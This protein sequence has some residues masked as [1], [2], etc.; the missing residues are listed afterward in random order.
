MPF[1]I[2]SSLAE[3]Y[4][5]KNADKINWFENTTLKIFML[6]RRII[7]DVSC[8]RSALYLAGRY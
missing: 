7:G 6:Y 1:L 5:G 3:N 8:Y 2:Q 4:L